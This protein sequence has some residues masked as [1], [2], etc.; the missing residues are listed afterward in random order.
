MNTR[1][2]YVAIA[3]IAAVMTTSTSVAFAQ[4]FYDEEACPDCDKMSA[5]EKGKMGVQRDIP[6]TIKTDAASYDHKSTIVVQGTVSTL[7]AGTEIGLIVVGPPPFNNIVAID[8]IKV[9][10]DGSYKTTLSTAGAA[11]KYDGTYTIKVTYGNQNINNRALVELTGGIAGIGSGCNP[12]ELAASGQCVPF[13]ITGGSI[14]S[15]MFSS[16][17][18]SLT[19]NI[20][21]FNDGKLTVNPS[22]DAI[23]GIFMVLVDGEEWDDVEIM[24][25]K[26]T[27]NFPAGTDKIEII[28]TF[29]IPEFGTIAAL[30]LAVAIISIIVVSSRTRLNVLPKY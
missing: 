19:I 2:S 28:G 22:T 16:A 7:K 20:S 6:I 25:N 3:I 18:K 27:V 29:A 24:G 15:A 9:A 4:G 17:S 11:W 30:I 1:T 26:V 8:Q 12:G 14:T 21:S 23:K 10:G 13:S 5:S